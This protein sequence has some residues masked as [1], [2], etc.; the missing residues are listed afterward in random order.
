MK[1]NGYMRDWKSEH[2]CH[3][4][5]ARRSFDNVMKDAIV[6]DGVARW[7]NMTNLVPMDLCEFVL[8]VLSVDE[9][10]KFEVDLVKQQAAQDV[11]L[12]Q[13]IA[14]EKTRVYTSEDLFEMR[15]A[16]GPGASMVNVLS[17]KRIQL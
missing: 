1:F 5:S 11:I 4:D 8:Q 12:D 14:R 15:A 10:Y 9:S 7:K 16:F 3:R 2:K 6:T 17:G 13:V